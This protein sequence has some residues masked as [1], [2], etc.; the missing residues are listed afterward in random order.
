MDNDYVGYVKNYRSTMG[1]VYIFASFAISWR[2]VLQDCT[3]ISTTKAEYV[4]ASV[5]CKE[6]IWLTH[7]VGEI[8][9]KQKLLVLHCDS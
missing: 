1:W 7:L 8:G 5:A 9:L 6:A 4:A 2:F 3:S